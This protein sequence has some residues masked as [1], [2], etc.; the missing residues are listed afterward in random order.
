MVWVAVTHTVGST[1]YAAGNT[2]DKLLG[3]GAVTYL[4]KA[5]TGAKPGTIK[6]TGAVTVFNSTGSLSGST[7]GIETT[8]SNGSVTQSGKTHPSD[9]HM[10]SSVRV[11]GHQ[12]RQVIGLDHRPGR[13]S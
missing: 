10:R 5:G 8:S 2:T 1:L 11:E 4:I 7:S 3:K 13:R 9:R 12:V 6:T